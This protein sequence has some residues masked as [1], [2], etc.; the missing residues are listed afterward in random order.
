MSTDVK[1]DV[2]FLNVFSVMAG[3]TVRTGQTRRT[4][5]TRAEVTSSD[6]LEVTRVCMR[7]SSVTETLIV[8]MGVMNFR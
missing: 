4:V 5:L 7:V 1:K 6:V 3:R 2:A 8:L